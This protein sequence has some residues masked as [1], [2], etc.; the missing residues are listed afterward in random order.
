MDRVIKPLKEMGA[1]I[2]ARGEDSYAPVS[3]LGNKDAEIRPIF[4]ELPVASAQVKSAVLLAGLYCNGWTAVS[5]KTRSRDH[6]ERMLKYFGAEVTVN[7]DGGTVSVKGLPVLRGQEMVIPGD[8]SSASFFMVAGCL[9]R[10]SEIL[11]TNVG[12]N[13]T[14]AG[15]IEALK[16]MG[17]GIELINKR[18][19]C[20]EPVA[21]I[22]VRY[23]PLRATEIRGEIIPRI[24]DEIPVLA[25]AACLAEG[26]TVIKDAAELRVKETDR[27]KIMA[28]ELGRMGAKIKEMED[29]LIIEGPVRLKGSRCKSHGDHRVAMALAVAGL[30]AEGET[31][32]EDSQCV[33]VSFP[34]FYRILQQLLS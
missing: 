4:Y 24:I 33:D 34:G 2:R 22:A 3:M 31:V 28:A 6:T 17:A 32:V 27:I 16:S 21:D 29:G 5:E 19:V 9:V 10:G 23:S 26:T 15:I 7:N 8:I 30:A 20:N 18:Q 14:R 12:V 1:L 11:I 25:V 13:F